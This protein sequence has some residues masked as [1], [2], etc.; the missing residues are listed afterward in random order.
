MDLRRAE[1]PEDARDHQVPPV[2]PAALAQGPENHPRAHRG[3]IQRSDA[4]VRAGPIASSLEDGEADEGH[5]G[6]D[7]EWPDVVEQRAGQ[8]E[9]PD[10]HFHQAGHHD[11]PLDLWGDT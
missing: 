1:G 9:Q 6:G 5:G 4:P 7:G 11:G 2:P 3:A 8:P 10:E